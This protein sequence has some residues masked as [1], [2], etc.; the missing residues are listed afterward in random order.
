[1]AGTCRLHLGG[2][3]RCRRAGTASD[4][5]H[6]DTTGRLWRPVVTGQTAASTAPMR[7]PEEITAAGHPLPQPDASAQ[8]PH[9]GFAPT[10]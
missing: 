1:M 6:A 7:S 3:W 2:R 10:R 5:D 4:T 8:A 9:V